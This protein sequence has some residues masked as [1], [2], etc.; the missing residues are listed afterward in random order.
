MENTQQPLTQREILQCDHDAIIRIEEMLK[1]SI[2]DRAQ[3][4]DILFGPKR[5]DG[6]VSAV[7]WI[8]GQM[9]WYW[10]LGGGMFSALV[11]LVVLHVH[12]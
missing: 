4:N 9:K 7:K 3:I 5:D 2:Q 10:F 6:L 12:I 11:Y 1:A 8:K